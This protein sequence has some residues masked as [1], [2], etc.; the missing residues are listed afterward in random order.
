M[1]T[2]FKPVGDTL[3]KDLYHTCEANGGPG[4]VAEHA[5]F[6][7][8]NNARQW[9]TQGYYFWIEDIH[10]AHVWGR[11]SINGDYAIVR[12]KVKFGDEDHLDLIGSPLHIRYFKSLISKYLEKMKAEFD[13]RYEPTVHEVIAQ[14]RKWA[15]KKPDLFPFKAISCCDDSKHLKRKFIKPNSEEMLALNERQQ[16]CLFQGNRDLIHEKEL[17]HPEDWCA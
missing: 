10:F 9:L 1:P 12:S 2:L 11:Q 6:L 7:S 14:Y 13:E 4:I 16:L 8:Q 3:D 15:E 5:P 17:V